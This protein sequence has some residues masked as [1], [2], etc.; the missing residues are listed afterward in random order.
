MKSLTIFYDAECG[1]CTRFRGW[2]LVQPLRV[3]VEFVDYRSA[4][5]TKRLPVL[6]EHGADREVVVMSDDGRWWQGAAAWVT[7]LW[8]TREYAG[9]AHRLSSPAL[10]PLVR[11]AVHLV[12]QNRLKLSHLLHLSSDADL[13]GRIRS[14]SDP[15]CADGSCAVPPPLPQ[16]TR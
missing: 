16:A 8:A 15:V 13:A 6:P 2:L 4:E 14:V 1:L 7:C 5:A 10:L 3:A 12:S 11:K 9:W